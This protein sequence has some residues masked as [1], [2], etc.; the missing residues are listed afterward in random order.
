M[1]VAIP[2]KGRPL[3][4]KSQKVI[5]SAYVFVPE[6]E[7][8]AYRQGG[9]QNLVSVPTEARGITNTRN[10]ILDW[11]LQKEGGRRVVMID[12]DV[13]AQ[14][15]KELLYS[16]AKDRPLN[17]TQ[18]IEE[19]G[20]LFDLTEDMGFRIWGVATQNAPRSV[21]PWKPFLE[22]SYVTGSCMG[23]LN[24]T[25]NPIRFDPEFPVKEDYEICL[26]CIK[27]DGG[28]VAA[29]H[30]YWVNSHW[31]DPGGCVEYRTQDLEEECIRKLRRKYP[32]MIRR[33]TRGG[34]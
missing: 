24:P 25:S 26:R 29:R 21:Y 9:V 1:I 12:D 23:I 5:P 13:K 32:G 28:V 15:W 33:V 2:S 14:G 31:I 11:A 4:V 34:E 10:W 27:E 8:K 16:S 20:K 22:R 3:R 6:Q 7:E 30:L 19:W 17:E 18:W